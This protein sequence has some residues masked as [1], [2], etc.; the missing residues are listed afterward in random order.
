MTKL[1][2]DSVSPTQWVLLALI[3]ALIILYPILTMFRN[4]KEREKFDQLA[5]DLKI[6]DKILTSSGTYGEIIAM[7]QREQSTVLTLKTGDSKHVGYLSVDVLTVY[8]VFR[9]KEEQIKVEEVKEEKAE[10]E[11]EEVEIK[12]EKQTKP[13]TGTTKKSGKK[14]TK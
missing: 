10:V 14:A 4:K 2:T 7:K 8:S 1:L 6:G 9:D 5:K 13:K 12:E 3:V 11:T